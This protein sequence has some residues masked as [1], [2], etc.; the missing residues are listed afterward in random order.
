[1]ASWKGEIAFPRRVPMIGVTEPVTLDNCERE[2]IQLLGQ[3]QA[4][5]TLLAFDDHLRLVRASANAQALL[6][7]PVPALGRGLSDAEPWTAIRD[8]VR[9]E[10]ASAPQHPPLPHEHEVTL[11]GR[12]FDLIVH[13]I[14]DEVVAEFELRTPSS[15]APARF[16]ADAH[17]SL[18]KLRR[19]RSIVALLEVAV[20]EMR[21][22]TG[23]DRVMAYR[24]RHDASGDV[25]AE[26]RI[27]SLEPFLG[28]RYPA[29]DIPAQARRLYMVNTLRLI[30]DV[31]SE[32][33]PVVG[34]R[35]QPLDMSHCVLR[36]VSPVHIEYLRNMGV[37]A[38]MSVSI[39]V[40]GQLWGM[41]ACHHGTALQVPYAV[42]MACDVLGQIVAA[43]VQSLL[44]GEAAQ[45]AA[46]AAKLRS[47]LVERTLQDDDALSALASMADGLMAGFDAHALLIADGAKLSVHGDVPPEAA[48]AL[49]QWLDPERGGPRT[50]LTALSSLEGL[51]PELRDAMGKWCGV[52][53]LR[54]DDHAPGWMVLLRKEQVETIDWGGRPEKNYTIGPLGPR[55][56][57][58]GSF[59]VWREEVRGKAEPWS[60]GDLELADDLLGE[61]VRAVGTRH[62][63]MS[64]A[65]DQLLAVLGHDLRNPLQT[66]SMAAH[67][68]ERGADSSKLGQRIRDSSSQMQRLI[69]QVLDMSR[70]QAGLGLGFSFEEVDV[71]ALVDRVA[72]D[73]LLAHPGSVIE[74]DLAGPLPA[75][76]DADRLAQMLGNLMSNAQHH[77]ELGQPVA[78]RAAREGDG[79]VL[80]V[81]NAAAPIP[82]EVAADLFTP[83]KRQAVGN[84]RN[85]GG[86]GLG[87]YIANEIARGHG[88]ALSYSYEEPFVVFTARFPARQAG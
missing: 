53:A 34:L 55:L 85:R 74:R 8:A 78:I 54:Y 59:S 81:R 75:Q 21:A 64:R 63:E 39:V 3:V 23:F 38:S 22:L 32:P 9:L 72:D 88:G 19:Q 17:R 79:V 71:A 28:R 82:P 52:L 27:D 60:A 15:A 83:F 45:R 35:E 12:L 84:R 48:R 11:G 44:A 70:I 14:G 4:H 40:G 41:L 76:A 62:A 36:S 7:V 67:V 10:A 37:E 47:R 86:L 66:I 58:R 1:M 46:R 42:R 2:Q 6:G 49:L 31:R 26:A 68:L 24:F 16:A 51:P 61:V 50:R 65:R 5:G 87:L 69:S 13:R 73:L 33:V 20:E 25:A 56:T 29:S 30:A 57:P 18:D 43:N 80:Q 77:G